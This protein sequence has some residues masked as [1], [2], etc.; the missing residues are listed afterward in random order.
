MVVKTGS[1]QLTVW[2]TTAL[3]FALI[4]GI[5][6]VA[7]NMAGGNVSFIAAIAFS[8]ILLG[9]QWYF[10]PTL[11]RWISGAKEV[12]EQQAPEI[13]QMVGKLAAGAGIPKPKVYVVENQTP[14]AFAFGRT[15]KSAGI[16]VHTGLLRVLNKEEVNAVIAHEIGHIKNNDVVIM[17]LASV[18][19]VMLYYIALATLGRGD[20]DR[21]NPLAAWAGA[22]AAQFIGQLVVLWLSR[23]REYYADAHSAEAIGDPMPLAKALV[24]ITYNIPKEASAANPA[25]NTLYIA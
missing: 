8:L 24:K 12:S 11:V 7:I 4:A 14:N 9:I 2:A 23:Q 13:H 16:A 3:I 20:D 17:T 5:F 22:M 18:I 21:P 1:L 15:Q 25:M 6:A 10:G 19:P